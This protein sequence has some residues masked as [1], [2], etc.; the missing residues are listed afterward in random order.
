MSSA[1][2]AFVVLAHPNSTE[3]RLPTMPFCSHLAVTDKALS[4]QVVQPMAKSCSGLLPALPEP[5][6]ADYIHAETRQHGA[7]ACREDIEVPAVRV[8]L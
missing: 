2:A 1:L 4:E 8:R 6:T 7:S 3:V 5:G